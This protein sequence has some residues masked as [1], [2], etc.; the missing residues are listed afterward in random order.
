MIDG[1]IHAEACAS[2]YHNDT[3]ESAGHLLAF[4]ASMLMRTI[5]P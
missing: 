2:R 5:R 3:I 1:M 4:P